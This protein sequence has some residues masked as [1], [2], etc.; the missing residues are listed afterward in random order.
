MML[1]AID[2]RLFAPSPPE[3][4]AAV[5]VLVGLFGTV[6]VAARASYILDISALPSNRFEP[7]GIAAS[8]GEPLP[9]WTVRA[10]IA[11]TIL[12]GAAFT[13]G[14]RYRTL[15]PMYAVGLLAVTTYSNCWQH[16]AHTDNLL[17]LHTAVLAVAPAAGAWSLDARRVGLSPPPQLG[18]GW[19]L[20]LM[21]LLTV[22]TYVL[23]GVAK[24]RHGG[25]V[26]VSGDVLRNLIAH[27][28]LRKILLGDVHSPVG[29]W[30]VAHRWVFPPLALM[31]LAVE[32]GAPLALLGGRVRHVWVAAA[33]F[34]HV[35]VLALMAITFFYPLSG[36]A[37]ASMLHPEVLVTRVSTKL[38]RPTAT[39][40]L[41]VAYGRS[42]AG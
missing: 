30:F 19:A 11:A 33:W 5:R 37:F 6:Y 2:R 17:V 26:W 34:F 39:D 36:I 25:S 14:W 35:G 24:L 12:L 40:G 28:N 27:D 20:R 15:A 16:V 38:R 4:I 23:A 21:S 29:G 13:A 10:L 41:S 1:T 18:W 42:D 7:V 8:L 9:M 31:S 22:I 32:M 3:R